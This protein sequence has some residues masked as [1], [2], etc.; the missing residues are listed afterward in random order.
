MALLAHKSSEFREAGAPA[1]PLQRLTTSSI[2]QQYQK[3]ATS[4]AFFLGKKKS[5]SLPT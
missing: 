2:S 1:L 5:A 3:K 4:V